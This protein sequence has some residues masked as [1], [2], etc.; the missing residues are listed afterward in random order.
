LLWPGLGP[1]GANRKDKDKP[2]TWAADG[3]ILLGED[4]VGRNLHRMELAVLSACETGLGDVAGGEGAFGLQRAFHVAGCKNVVASLWQG[5]D[6]A[7][8]GLMDPL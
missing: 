6:D 1:A 5:D 7:Q 4:I 8:A 3:G 2:Q